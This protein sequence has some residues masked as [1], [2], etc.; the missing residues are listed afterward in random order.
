MSELFS[1]GHSNQPFEN[2]AT[3]LAA[4]GVEVVVDVRSAPVSRWASQY[5]RAVLERALPEQGIDYV[6][7]GGTLGGRPKGAEFYDA[8][9]HVLY[10]P[11]S[12]APPFLAG[13]EELLELSGRRRVAV[14]CSEEDPVHCHR[15]LLI[16]PVLDRRGIAVTHLR[17]DGSEEDE[18]AV[19]RRDV[20]AQQPSLFEEGGR[21]GVAPDRGNGSG[22]ARVA[23]GGAVREPSA[24]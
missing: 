23:P 14:M 21:H 7:M 2:L 16:G 13:L 15:R 18:A 4:H 6:Y 8:D 12:E 20:D 9:G 5:N 19:A 1:V 24:R 3:V 10:G 22:G 17:A 11:L